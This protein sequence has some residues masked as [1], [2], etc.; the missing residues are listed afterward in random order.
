MI[1]SERSDD[2]DAEQYK[3]RAVELE[4]FHMNSRPDLNC[5]DAIRMYFKALGID[6]NDGFARSGMALTFAA[7]GK[8]EDAAREA[9]AAVEHLSEAIR[10]GE[11]SPNPEYSLL[12][13][14][15][16]TQQEYASHCINAVN[17]DEGFRACE[18]AVTGLVTFDTTGDALEEMALATASYF[19]DLISNKRR[20][21]AG[22]LLARMNVHPQRS[23][24]S[25]HIIYR[26]IAFK[27]IKR[28]QL[29]YHTRNLA[30]VTDL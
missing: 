16:E 9:K 30:L 23:S 10:N 29:G 4:S 24:D 18:C 8:Y 21:D 20:D 12:T 22:S 5:Y 3:P 14:K 2:N 1:R 6:G 7:Q 28:S 11:K 19:H 13:Y 26:C 15:I 17:L 27:E 25:F